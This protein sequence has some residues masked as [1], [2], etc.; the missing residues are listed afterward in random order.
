MSRVKELLQ[1]VESI[2][3]TKLNSKIKQKINKE[4]YELTKSRPSVQ[5]GIDKMEDILNKYGLKT[6]DYIVL[7]KKGKA[8]LDL[9][10]IDG[11][12]IDNSILVFDWYNGNLENAYVS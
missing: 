7:G 11:E 3:E 5:V 6:E 1:I 12:S 10:T 4:L 8:T 9:Y 2:D